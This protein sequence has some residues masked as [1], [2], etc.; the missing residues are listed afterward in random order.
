[1]ADH[2]LIAYLAGDLDDA[3]RLVVEADLARDPALREELEAWRLLAEA[4]QQRHN[5][6]GL[7]ARQAAFLRELDGLADVAAPAIHPVKDAPSTET[8]SSS[9]GKA[10]ETFGAGSATQ[11]SATQ[12]SAAPPA[13]AIQPPS[14]PARLRAAWRWLWPQS[15]G[16]MLPTGWALALVLLVV[17]M[18]PSADRPQVDPIATRGGASCAR[19]IVDLPDSVSVAQLRDVLTQYAVDVTSGPDPDGRFV[20]SAV[21][22]DSLRGA[23]KA[24]GALGVVPVVDGPCVKAQP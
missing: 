5:A 8:I 23:A 21:R 7:A 22:E 19:W 12:P 18:T 13:S 14:L 3:A 2:R 1:M 20:M 9:Q 10:S 17:L 6:D 24:L 11:P 16:P 15:A 4:D